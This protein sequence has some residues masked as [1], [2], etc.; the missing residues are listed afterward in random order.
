MPQRQHGFALLAFVV[1]MVLA[2]ITIVIGE[3]ALL[4]K[5][6]TNN[7][8]GEK[9]RYLSEVQSRIR[10]WYR[11]NLGTLDSSAAVPVS[12]AGLIRQSGLVP[13]WGLRV[14]LSNRLT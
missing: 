5:S 13:K 10:G 8:E 11:E 6:A 3:S 9:L 7:L 14:A 12:E 4:A 1:V 2:A